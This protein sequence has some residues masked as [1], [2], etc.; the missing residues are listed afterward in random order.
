MQHDQL[1]QLLERQLL[2]ITRLRKGYAQHRFAFGDQFTDVAMH[3]V[4]NHQVDI[5]KRLLE[6]FE[7][8]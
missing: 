8:G 3:R 5:G 2:H 6:R 1:A 4:A 7:H